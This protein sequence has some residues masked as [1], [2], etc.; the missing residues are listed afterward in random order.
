MASVDDW[1]YCP[2]CPCDRCEDYRKEN[3]MTCMYGVGIKPETERLHRNWG[4][5][6][7]T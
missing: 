2:G 6:S 1:S 7:N 3:G 5:W 4:E